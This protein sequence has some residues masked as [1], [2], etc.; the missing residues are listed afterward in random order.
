MYHLFLTISGHNLSGYLCSPADNIYDIEFTRFK[1]RDM[2]TGIV[3]FEIVK[4]P[5]SSSQENSG[6]KESQASLTSLSTDR[7]T[8]S[9]RFVRYQFS[10]NFL[11]LKTV[12]AT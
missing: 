10:P 12:G 2:E 6:D 5:Q 3:L 11:K 4:S 1:I 8:S 9:G 7:F